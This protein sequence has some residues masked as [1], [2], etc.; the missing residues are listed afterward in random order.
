MFLAGMKY[1]VTQ[2]LSWNNINRFPHTSF[3]WEGIDGTRVLAHF[4]PSNTYTAQATSGE[5][6]R[7]E[8]DHKDVERSNCALLLYGH[9]D[10]GG[11]PTY[12]MLN[13]LELMEQ[14]TGLG[15][16]KV[17]FASPIEFF[18]SLEEDASTLLNWR[19]ELYF[20]LHRGTYTSQARMKFYNRR[21]EGL[22]KEAEL[23]SFAL[24]LVSNDIPRYFPKDKLEMLWKDLL[25]NQFHDVLPGSGI[26]EVYKDAAQIYE[27]LEFQAVKIREEAMNYLFGNRVGPSE[28]KRQIE[29]PLK[30]IVFF[31]TTPYER[32]AV[33]AVPW[34]GE[35][36]S[37]QRD[38]IAVKGVK[39]FS[40][41]T[42]AQ[43]GI[44]D[45]SLIH[46]V[47]IKMITRSGKDHYVMENQF[48]RLFIDEYGHITH[49]FDKEQQKELVLNGHK[50]NQFVVYEDIPYYWDAWDVELHHREKCCPIG[51]NKADVVLS[52]GMEGP[53]LVSL[54]RVIKVSEFSSIHQVITLSCLSKRVDFTC[55]IDWHE[56]HLLLKVLFP[57]SIHREFAT[58]ECPFGY[59]ARPT[60]SNTSWDLARFEVCGHRFAD[61]SEPNYGVA[62]L[63]NCK[64]GYS[65]HGS[66]LA[67]SLLRSPKSPDPDCD[68]G[69]HVM[70]FALFPHYGDHIQG[71]VVEEA[72]KFNTE[73]LWTSASPEK[74]DERWVGESMLQFVPHNTP[75]PNTPFLTPLAIETC[76]LAEDT[77]AVIL[78]AYEPRGCRGLAELAP[79]RLVRI[80]S[81]VICDLLE[82][83]LLQ[84]DCVQTRQLGDKT[85]WVIEYSPF[86]V[87][88]LRLDIELDPDAVPPHKGGRFDNDSVTSFINIP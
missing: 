25:L 65:V 48:L 52:I 73:L 50:A 51:T 49:C 36:K 4:P 10:G 68:M 31:N 2:K 87:I 22:L 38:I 6:L 8:K 75:N 70:K 21:C 37:P 57:V 32:D 78:R 82:Q 27:Q 44:S 43:T 64:Y 11:G 34:D 18:N 17:D 60:H 83:D 33:L 67:L 84:Q 30:T 23:L 71:K 76:K 74:Y 77:N 85:V 86:Q 1:F 41:S 69:T 62:L 9:G 29:D 47:S 63:N 14:N 72:I 12:E 58:F 54:L 46:P 45:A 24:G 61:L 81:V 42:F 28:P 79:H 16:P 13:R 15:L 35:N 7:S 40:M 5:I 88:T 3:W 80:K 55:R 39:G 56:E 20:E 19:G 26:G 66:C 59:V 53:L